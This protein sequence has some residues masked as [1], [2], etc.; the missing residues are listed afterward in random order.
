MREIGGGGYIERTQ[1]VSAGIRDVA[2]VRIDLANLAVPQ[3]PEFKQP[4]LAPEHVV[5]P[6]RILGI[7]GTRTV[8]AGERSEILA[9]VLAVTHALSFPAIA[10]DAVPFLK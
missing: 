10:Q 4:L 3:A 9:A 5:T 6:S 8:V 7:A 1:R 2:G